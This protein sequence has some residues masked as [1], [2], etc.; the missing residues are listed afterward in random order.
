MRRRGAQ[1]CWFDYMAIYYHVDS[2]D[3]VFNYSE[4]ASAGMVKG[5]LFV[6]TVVMEPYAYIS[7]VSRNGASNMSRHPVSGR[8]V[9][10]DGDGRQSSSG[11]TNPYSYTYIHI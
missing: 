7:V 1:I 9:R 4:K 8:L 3:F 10:G 5:Y 11:G 6:K 2:K